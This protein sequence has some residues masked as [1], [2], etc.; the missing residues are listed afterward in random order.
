[1]PM[2]HLSIDST[3][4]SMILRLHNTGKNALALIGSYCH[5][6]GDEHQG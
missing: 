3:E 2:L 5:R 4:P 1:M 6:R